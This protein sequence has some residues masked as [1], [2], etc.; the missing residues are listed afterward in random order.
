LISAMLP[1]KF[2]ANCLSLLIPMRS[3]FYI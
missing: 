3:P 2:F 1:L